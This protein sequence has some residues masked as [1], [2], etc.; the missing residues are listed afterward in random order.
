MKDM[1]QKLT[2]LGFTPQNLAKGIKTKQCQ[3]PKHVPC[4]ECPIGTIAGTKEDGSGGCIG[5]M[6]ELFKAIVDNKVEEVL[7]E[8]SKTN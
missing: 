1:M 2:T 8:S 5:V 3:M 4:W 6:A 7:N